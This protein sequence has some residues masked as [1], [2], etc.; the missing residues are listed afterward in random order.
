MIY[1]YLGKNFMAQITFVGT[2]YVGLVNGVALAEMGHNVICFDTDEKRIKSLNKGQM[3]IYEPGLKEML[4]SNHLK[5][6]IRFSSSAKQA[7]QNA[8]VI[9]ICVGTPQ[10]NDGNAN[11]SSIFLAIGEISA[12]LDHD[13]LIVVKSTVPVGSCERIE[14]AIAESIKPGFWFE[15]AS[16]PEFLAQGSALHDALHPTRIVIG[17]KSSRAETLLKKVYATFD[18]PIV[19]VSRESAEMI[20]YA[21]NSFLALKISYIN[22]V[23]NYCEA[24]GANILEVSQGMKYD[25][26][27]GSSF[28]NAG[29]GFGGSCL[30]KDSLAFCTAAKSRK[31][32]LH[33]LEAAIAV[34]AQQKQRLYKKAE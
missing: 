18:S 1:T 13:C 34:N 26:R 17:I 11:L 24:V 9:V 22:E 20:K 7:Y 10:D 2:G 27:I 25:P 28:L 8:E 33:T 23:A 30:P 16:N 21:S 6:R 19:C 32:P 3:P 29:I 5:G 12:H 15:V 31:S 4:E 14:K